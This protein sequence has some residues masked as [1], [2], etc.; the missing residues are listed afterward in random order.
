MN[1][2]SIG[3]ITTFAAIAIALNAVKIPTIFYPGT[4][5]EFSQ[6]PIVIAFVLFGSRTG[7]IVGVLNLGG[8][9]ALF[10]LGNGLIV[11][12][13]DFLA[14]LLMFAGIYIASRFVKHSDESG[15]ISIWRKPV[16]RLTGLAIAIRGGIMPIVD[17]VV[18]YHFLIRLVLGI[19][20]SEALIVAMVPGFILYN[21][22]MPL[23]TIP[24]AYVVA[25]K[26]T[27]YL[28]IE[29]CFL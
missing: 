11:Y 2:K 17:Y 24:V 5:F 1:A 15:K 18:I 28:K 16:I 12:P 8:S 7:I 22:L 29:S 3:L 6:I 20:L 9:L 26:V 25:A 23:Y 10:P 4:F 14:L 19:T 27:R 13:M 21:V